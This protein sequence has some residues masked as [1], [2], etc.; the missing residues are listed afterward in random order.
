MNNTERIIKYIDLFGTKCTFYS[1]KMP[2]YYTVT[3]G[4]FSIISI[5]CCI[6]IFIALSL[7]DIKR[8]DP[9][10]TISSIPSKGYRK[11][12]FGEE[13]IWIPWRIIDFKNNKLVNHTGI[14]FPIIYYYSGIK[15][16]ITNNI[17]INTKLLNYKLC[18]ETSM[19]YKDNTYLI[20]VP[21]NELY[22]IEMDDLEMGGSWINEFINYIEFD[23][24]FCEDGVDYDEEN[25]KCTSNTKISNLI[26]KNNSLAIALYYPVIQFQPTNETNPIIILYR[27][28]FYHISKYTNKIERISLQENV[29][30]DDL[31]W[32][33]K[34]EYNNSY[35]GLESISGDSYY[36]GYGK[37]LMDEGSNSRVYSFNIHL[38]PGIIHY[39]RYYKKV[40]NIFNDFFPIAYIVFIIIKNIAKLFKKVES[41][42]KMTELLFE[43]L[44]EKPNIFEEKLEKLRINNNINNNISKNYANI[45]RFSLNSLNYKKNAKKPKARNKHSVDLHNSYVNRLIRY[46][47]FSLKKSAIINNENKTNNNNNNNNNG[48][49]KKKFKKKLLNFIHKI[50]KRIV[51]YR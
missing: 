8:K 40:Y 47:S 41:N 18:N 48:N 22:C 35:W 51:I 7:G 16:N 15:D 29:L 27:Q 1:D 33:F 25:P 23:L 31:G 9:I 21:L 45:R 19:A 43:N 20:T 12:K 42:R 3:G 24:Y 26:G 46:S 13:K 10:T 2:K 14:L 32:I 39:K 6:I 11:I 4:F 44:K 37:E 36:T 34:I 50:K 30:T 49:S 28:Y 5:F 38:E 17:N